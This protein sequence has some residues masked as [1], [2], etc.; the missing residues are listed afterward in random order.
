MKRKMFPGIALFLTLIMLIGILP[1][2]ALAIND[3]P[4]LTSINHSSVVSAVDVTGKNSA[5]L[6]VPYT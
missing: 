3:E 5:T 1:F 2:T 6:T 4:V